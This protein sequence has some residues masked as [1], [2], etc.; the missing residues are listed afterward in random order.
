MESNKNIALRIFYDEEIGKLKRTFRMKKRR[1][2]NL[3]TNFSENLEND[4][5]FGKLDANIANRQI[6]RKGN[7]KTNFS[8]FKTKKSEYTK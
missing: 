1:N 4:E 7:F 8:D 3:K 5:L 2:R 6:Q